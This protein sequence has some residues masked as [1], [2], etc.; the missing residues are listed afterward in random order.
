M[1]QNRGNAGVIIRADI[2]LNVYPPAPLSI[3]LMLL[4]QPLPPLS[5][6]SEENGAI[7][8]CTPPEAREG[9]S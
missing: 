3:L 5:V 2:N 1:E 7:S 6:E 4:V 9:S 8:I